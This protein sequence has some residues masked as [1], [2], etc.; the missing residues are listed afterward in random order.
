MK[1]NPGA[2]LLL[3][4][5]V[6]FTY[7]INSQDDTAA[8]ASETEADGD[9]LAGD[10]GQFVKLPNG[11]D[12]ETGE[13]AAPHLGGAITPY[14]EVWRQLHPNMDVK[15]QFFPDSKAWILES[16][17]D[18]DTVSSH[19]SESSRTTPKTFLARVGPFFIAIRRHEVR[20]DNLDRG[21]TTFVY[22]A[23]REGLDPSSGRWNTVYSVGDY[24]NLWAMS[25]GRRYPGRN[26]EAGQSSQVGDVLELGE[27]DQ[28]ERYIIRAISY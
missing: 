25:S 3:A 26:S 17:S 20:K 16:V 7:S 4:E 18:D 22:G 23:I 9:D 1:L 24:S 28:L 10:V 19:A 14:E 12:F 21:N 15:D 13:M 5:R 6:K 2:N 8:A 27:Q 11:D